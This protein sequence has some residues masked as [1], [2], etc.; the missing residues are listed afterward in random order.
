MTSASIEVEKEKE[1]E[2]ETLKSSKLKVMQ[3]NIKNI[4]LILNFAHFSKNT[5]T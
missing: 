2:R 1:S 3:K 5:V 4:I